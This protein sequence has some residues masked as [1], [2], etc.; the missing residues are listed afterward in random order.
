MTHNN[1][2]F[3]T[4]PPFIDSNN[5]YTVAELNTAI[6]VQLQESFGVVYV[7]GEISNLV[8]ATSGHYYFTLKDPEGQIRC[9][10]FKGYRT[11]IKAKIENGQKILVKAKISIYVP[12]GDYQLIIEHVYPTGLGALQQAFEELKKK[13]HAEGLFHEN[14][15]KPIPKL[16][17][18]IFVITS[19]TGAAIK[20]ILTTLQRRFATIPIKIIP[21]LVQGI[22]AADSLIRALT[23]A[24]Q[25]ANHRTDL[26]ILARG[27]GSLEDLWAFN[28]EQLA[29]TIFSLKTPLISGVGHE[30]DFTIA[31]LVADL[32]AATPTAA[33]EAASAH[34]RE[35]M[36]YFI[37]I[38]QHLIQAFK[39][40]LLEWHHLLK[41]RHHAMLQ[42]HPKNKILNQFQVLD[43]A[44]LRLKHQKDKYSNTWQTQVKVLTHRLEQ[45]NPYRSIKLELNN[46]THYEK[47]LAQN[48]RNLFSFYTNNLI[49]NIS[50]LNAI[51]P[52]EVLARG[53]SIVQSSS[54]TIL[55]SAKLVTSGDKIHIKFYDGSISATVNNHEEL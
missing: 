20:D 47:S 51:N 30:V 44:F 10:L 8:K 49:H 7:E 26:L 5:I 12:K 21:S 40:S 32:R 41:D 48:V 42:H 38:E 28:D 9:A 39:L 18:Q 16:P 31:D 19:P 29:R 23:I 37:N 24:D 36:D 25:H 52:L 35:Y 55:K 53:Y 43:E 6:N 4:L 46:L 50:R 14:H 33:A 15:K 13:L 3:S 27:G 11:F 17:K 45:Q 54:G 2:T 1:T 34:W 22:T